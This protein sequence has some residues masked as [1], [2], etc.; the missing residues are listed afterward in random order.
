MTN[1]GGA[2]GAD[3]PTEPAAGDA[4]QKAVVDLASGMSNPEKLIALGAI[5][6]LAINAILGEGILD[7][8]GVSQVELLLT[9]GALAAILRHGKGNSQ[10]H[11]LYPWIVE[12][13]AG[14]YAALGT[15]WTIDWL[16]DG[17]EGLEGSRVFYTLVY[18]ASIALMGYG[19]WQLHR[20]H[21]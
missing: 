20:A 5:L 16:L 12:A 21:D 17:F 2:K 6:F 13:L 10:W 4:I 19:A 1:E 7:T 9:G 15:F 18:W 3:T 14:A 8:Y 11:S